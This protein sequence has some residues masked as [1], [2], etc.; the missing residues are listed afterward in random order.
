MLPYRLNCKEKTNSKNPKV[1]RTKNGR[2]MAISNCT[3]SI[4]KNQDFSKMEKPVDYRPGIV[5]QE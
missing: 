5:A 1:V 3:V 2:I 4:V